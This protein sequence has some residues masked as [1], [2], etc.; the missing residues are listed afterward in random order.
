MIIYPA[1]D[2][3]EGN[4]VR[5]IKGD[6]AQKTVYG[7]PLEVARSYREDGATR[8]HV[9]DLDGAKAGK[10]V[11]HHIIGKIAEQ[12]L[13]IE[14]GGGIRTLE[15]VDALVA[16][17]VSRVIIGTAAFRDKDFLKRALAKYGEKIAV[18]VDAKNG[19]VAVSAWQEEVSVK[20]FDFVKE[21]HGLGVSTIIYTDISKDG[22]LQGA[23]VSET[24]RLADAFPLDIIASGGVSGYAD[25]DA[26][27]GVH[28][29]IIGKALFEKKLILKDVI[30]KYQ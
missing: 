7:D 23:N 1:I 22:M 29:V 4:C 19:N 15:S 14:A 12:G 25:L 5:L 30:K 16:A 24:V 20:A 26:L 21:L 2:I 18:G 11:N 3:I 8:I 6:Y 9:V 10:P 17:G 28:G 13:F 27:T